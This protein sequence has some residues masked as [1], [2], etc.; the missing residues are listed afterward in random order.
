M[1]CLTPPTEGFP[2]DDLRKILPGC[3]QMASVPNGV[4]TMPKISTARV[5]RTNVTDRQTDV[6]Q[7]TDGRRHIA[8]VN[9]CSRSN[10]CSLKSSVIIIGSPLYALSNEP[11]MNSVR[12][13]YA[14]KG[15]LKNAKCC[16]SLEGSLLQIFL[17]ILSA[18]KLYMGFRLVAKS[19]SLNDLE[20]R[21]SSY[22][23]LFHRIRYIRKPVRSQWLKINL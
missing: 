9:V 16:T 19:L 20:R 13:H 14:T 10:S 2:W 1:S 5:E 11:Q 18:T 7:T 12:C 17:S 23:E 21:N 6:R 3:Q 8:N 4:E 22:F 15:G